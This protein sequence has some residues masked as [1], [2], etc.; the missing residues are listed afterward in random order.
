MIE[1]VIQCKGII[2]GRKKHD[3]KCPS[4]RSKQLVQKMNFIHLLISLVVPDLTWICPQAN[5]VLSLHSPSFPN[6]HMWIRS[7]INI[8]AN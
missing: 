4:S 8:L 7:Y 2:K 3:G 5:L 1:D 6:C